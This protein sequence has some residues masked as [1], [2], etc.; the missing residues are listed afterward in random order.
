MTAI[1]G[2]VGV[3]NGNRSVVLDI[4]TAR[5]FRLLFIPDSRGAGR[6]MRRRLGTSASNIRAFVAV[7][8][9]LWECRFTSAQ[10]KGTPGGMV[11]LYR[12][13]D[14]FRVSRNEVI[15]STWLPWIPSRSRR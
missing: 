8:A 11:C 9:C 14:L 3:R 7:L 13:N 15:C 4:V 6:L 2:A 10:G 12:E 1:A 5:S